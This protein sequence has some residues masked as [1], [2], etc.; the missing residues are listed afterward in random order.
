MKSILTLILL[1][2][3]S[4]SATKAEMTERVLVEGLIN[5]WEVLTAPDGNIWFTERTGKVT[6][7]NPISL[8]RKELLRVPD[9]FQNNEGGLLGM[10]L[11]PTLI[12]DI[13]C[14][15]VYNYRG[16]GNSTLEKLVRYTYRNDT[17][18]NPEI[19]L[20]GIPGASIHNGSRLLIMGLYLYMTTGDAASPTSAQNLSSLSGKVLRFNLDGSIPEDNPFPNSYIWSY[21]HRNSQGLALV[22]DMLFASEHGASTDDEINII[23]KGANYGWPNVQGYCDGNISGEL[24]FC[25]ANTVVEPILSLTPEFTLAVCGID[26]YN[27]SLIPEWENSLLVATLKSQRLLRL[28]LNED[29]KSITDR[30]DLYISTYGRLRDV[31]VAP[32]GKVYLATSNS[33]NDK[34]VEISYK[35]SSVDEGKNVI[36]AYPNP[37]INF[38]T[39]P[40]IE[41]AQKIEIYNNNAKLMSAFDV[42]SE[43]NEIKID[44]KDSSGALLMSGVY[45]AKIYFNDRVSIIKLI[46]E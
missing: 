21:G 40:I 32:S 24:D 22:D 13:H 1:L 33:N 9:V 35:H 19:I 45:F 38:W 41:S 4:W 10:A 11:M 20:E 39:I 23:E 15:L 8:E 37:A 18:I 6:R 29:K 2:T 27:H 3:L 7:L 17:L 44:A 14:Y 46:K 26:Y 16:S 31:H 36:K 30:E 25:N 34:I 43:G 28:S 12:E 42:N 5:P